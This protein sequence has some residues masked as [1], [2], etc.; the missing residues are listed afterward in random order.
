MSTCRAW[1]ISSSSACSG[2]AP[3]CA[4]STTLSR[5]IMSVGIDEIPNDAAKSRC[6]SVSTLPNT[7]SG[8][9]SDARSNTGPNILHGPHHDAQKSTSTS[10]PSST[11][12]SKFAL[13]SS[14]VA[15]L[16]LHV[17]RASNDTPMGIDNGWVRGI[18]ALLNR[19][20]D[21]SLESR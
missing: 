7:A 8:L 19:L 2:N 12:D 15:M 21:Y 1:L 9:R 14:T 17:W 4:Y 13:V 3:G 10:P 16:Y 18:P 5:M 6:A 20:A 11:T